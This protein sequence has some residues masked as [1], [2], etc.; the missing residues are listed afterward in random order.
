M[1]EVESKNQAILVISKEN[2]ENMKKL[3]NSITLKSKSKRNLKELIEE[4]N[5]E[6]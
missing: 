5:L 3:K 4:V 6:K 2:E 1:L